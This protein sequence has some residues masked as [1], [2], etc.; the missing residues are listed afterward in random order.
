MF[1]VEK[2]KLTGDVLGNGQYKPGY[3]RAYFAGCTHGFANRGDPVRVLCYAAELFG[4][5]W[6]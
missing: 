4:A 5:H 3:T 2:Q 1:P 6:E